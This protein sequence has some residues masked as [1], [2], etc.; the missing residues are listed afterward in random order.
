MQ[1]TGKKLAIETQ[2]QN[3]RRDREH[4]KAADFPQLSLSDSMYCCPT[5]C[6]HVSTQISTSV[7][8]R[9]KGKKRSPNPG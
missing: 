9:L 8:W 2:T 3:P 5:P 4:E 1:S 6:S 7:M